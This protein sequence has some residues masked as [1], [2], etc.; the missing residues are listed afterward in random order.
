MDSTSARPEKKQSF[1][2]VTIAAILALASGI[3]LVAYLIS[4]RNPK[5]ESVERPAVHLASSKEIDS[6]I[7]SET[8]AKNASFSILNVWA[9]WC[10]PCRKEMPEMA[11]FQKQHPQ[12]PLLLVSA[13]NEKDLEAARQFL[14]DSK[15]ETSSRLLRGDQSEF[16]EEW[17]KRSN[18]DP[19]KQWSMSLPVTFF[20]D[21]KGRVLKF[22]AGGT[23]RQ[24]L[25]AIANGIMSELPA[26]Q[27]KS[28]DAL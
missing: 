11:D 3:V 23:T 22:I 17:Q 1:L 4:D 25:A 28:P 9:T 27:P 18:V 15:V 26:V 7:A 8:Q 2:N 19:A 14:N 10:E 24:E 6:W 5:V 13:D 12:W 16:I 21:Q 20:V